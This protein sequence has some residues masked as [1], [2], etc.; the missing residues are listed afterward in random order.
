MAMLSGKTDNCFI[1]MNAIKNAKHEWTKK[2]LFWLSAWSSHDRTQSIYI[3]NLIKHVWG[4]EEITE[5]LQRKRR[6]RIRDS[7]DELR[8]FGWYIQDQSGLLKIK[9]PKY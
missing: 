3:D 1:D 4:K 5:D 2:T 8:K 9:R 7:F 6:E